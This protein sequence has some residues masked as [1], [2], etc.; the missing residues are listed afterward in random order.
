MSSPNKESGI[1]KCTK[2]GQKETH[3]EKKHFAPC[4]SCGNNDWKLV[5]A[6]NK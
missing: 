2:C 4:S 1:Y 5:I 6:T 3:V